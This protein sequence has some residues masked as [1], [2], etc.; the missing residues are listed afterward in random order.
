MLYMECMEIEFSEADLGLFVSDLQSIIEF[1][2]RNT[3]ESISIISFTRL[4]VSI[5]VRTWTTAIHTQY[6]F[7]SNLHGLN[8]YKKLAVYFLYVPIKLEEG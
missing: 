5:P 8:Q 1:W 3:I 4:P 7:T 2:R 6:F